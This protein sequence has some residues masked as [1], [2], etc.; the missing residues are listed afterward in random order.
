MINNKCIICALPSEGSKIQIEVRLS[1]I[2]FL[3]LETQHILC[4][5]T[6]EAVPKATTVIW[7]EAECQWLYLAA[8]KFLLPFPSHSD[9]GAIMF[10]FNDFLIG[11]L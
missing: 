4:L 3:I 7:S 2:E 8:P 6:A 10:F 11:A 9:A 5:G 1:I